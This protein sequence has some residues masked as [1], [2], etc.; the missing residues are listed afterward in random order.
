MPYLKVRL[1][2]SPVYSIFNTMALMCLSAPLLSNF[3]VSQTLRL[4]LYSIYIL[5][6]G[7]WFI[8]RLYQYL[9]PYSFES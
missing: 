3:S 2:K 4:K 6:Y 1:P 8:S 9:R 7:L 5:V